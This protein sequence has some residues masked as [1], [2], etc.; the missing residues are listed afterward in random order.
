MGEPVEPIEDGVSSDVMTSEHTDPKHTPHLAVITGLSGA[1]RTTAAKA[2]ED[3][4]YFVIDNLPPALMSRVFDLAAVPGS[5]VGKIALV[6]DVRG[7]EFFGDLRSELAALGEREASP[8]ILFLESSDDTLVKRY[9][10]AR[11]VHPLSGNDR[12]LDGIQRERA[13]LA[14]LRAEA[15]LVIDTSDTNVHQLRDRVVD[16]FAGTDPTGMVANVVSFGFKNGVPRDA[17]LVFD[18]RFLANPH[19]VE[20]LRPQTGLEEDV[21]TYVMS[22]PRSGEFLERLFGLLDLM[23]PAFVEDAKR[24]LTIAIGCT[25][26][27]HRSVVMA[28]RV[29]AHLDE[30]GVQVQVEH[31][32]RIPG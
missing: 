25:G 27:K 3:L 17:D 11:R 23:V 28:E 24:Y 9:E 7:R 19:W 18:V 13:V 10:A 1:G 14:D 2:L 20:E 4:G 6:V 5:T 21:I 22:Q 12:L 16:A 29:A 30:L 8:T 15:D 32:D 26:G 31:R